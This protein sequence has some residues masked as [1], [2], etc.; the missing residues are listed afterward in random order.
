MNAYFTSRRAAIV[1][2]VGLLAALSFS[3]VAQAITDTVFRYSTPKTGFYSIYHHALNPLN[4]FDA[5]AY[6]RDFNSGLFNIGTERICFG[7]GVNLPHAATLS[8]VTVF[9]KS[10]GSGNPDFYFGATRLSTGVT[11]L[12]TRRPAD[13]TGTLKSVN[14]PVDPLVISN[15]QNSYAFEAC[16]NPNDAFYSARITYTYNNAGD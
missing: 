7:T 2:A 1:A 9:Y 10:G 4:H 14:I 3:G 5:V 13:D 6:L 15:N 8:A 11:T 12:F 16:I